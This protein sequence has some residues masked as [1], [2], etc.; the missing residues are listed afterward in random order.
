MYG[1]PAFWTDF[2]ALT[3]AAAE[4][5]ADAGVVFVGL[6]TPTPSIEHLHA[7]HNILLGA[8]C[9][10]AECLVGLDRLAHS[11]TY[12]VC[13]PLKLVGLDGAPARVIALDRADE[14]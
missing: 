8:G 10:L 9:V 12:L 14:P 5:L 11:E 1:T 3:P 7:T 4:Y 13:L 2:P 6:D